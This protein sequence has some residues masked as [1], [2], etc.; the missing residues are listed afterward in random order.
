M[1]LL[2]VLANIVESVINN[3]NINDFLLEYLKSVKGKLNIESLIYYT[4]EDETFTKTNFFGVTS[5]CTDSIKKEDIIILFNDS[6]IIKLN[7]SS[8]INSLYKQNVAY[9]ILINSENDIQRLILIETDTMNIQNASSFKEITTYFQPIINI[10]FNYNDYRQSL[11]DTCMKVTST[12]L[13]SVTHDVRSPIQMINIL[14]EML[15]AK[16]LLLEKRLN[17]YTRL[18]NGISQVDKILADV[19]DLFKKSYDIERSK[20]DCY[21]F[22]EEIK[23]EVTTLLKK[24]K[25]KFE[26][27]LEYK[28]NI[29]IDAEKIRDVIIKM[30]KYSIELIHRDGLIALSVEEIDDNI[31]I[32]IVDTSEGIEPKILSNQK[33]PFF[34]FGS[35]LGTGLNF[36]IMHSVIEAHSGKLTISNEKDG[37]TIFEIIIPKKAG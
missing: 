24:T 12:I 30:I 8:P 28:S 27:N 18:T 23:T 5:Q 13:R 36:S 31:N 19:S 11:I 29:E 20:V 10:A 25:I 17:L 7:E 4:L 15:K 37:G 34:N 32:S 6:S 33:N 21:T 16:E 9:A 3:D 14:L 35:R 26:L 22:F 2:N 1:I